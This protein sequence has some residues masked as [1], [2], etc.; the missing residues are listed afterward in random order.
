VQLTRTASLSSRCSASSA[1]EAGDEVLGDVD[2]RLVDV[3]LRRLE[4][5]GFEMHVVGHPR[6]HTSETGAS[7][8]TRRRL[9][10]GLDVNSLAEGIA[11]DG[12]VCTGYS[13]MILSSRRAAP[14]A[15]GVDERPGRL[16]P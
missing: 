16:R 12:G 5:L 4:I 11:L 8:S 9:R 13:G 7:S 6:S 2:K 1:S 15:A 10:S 3:R 14:V